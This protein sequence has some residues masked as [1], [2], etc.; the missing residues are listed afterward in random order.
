MAQVPGGLGAALGEELAAGCALKR[1][2]WRGCAVQAE[3]H[4]LT[5]TWLWLCLSPKFTQERVCE[6]ISTS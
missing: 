1:R 2:V 4:L 3:T 6:G 5:E